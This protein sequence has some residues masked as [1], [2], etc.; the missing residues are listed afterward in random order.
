MERSVSEIFAQD[1]EAAFRGIET[2]ALKNLSQL[3]NFV[4]A[5]GGGTPCFHKNMRY[6][7]KNGPS[8]YLKADPAFLASR[9]E[10][11]KDRP[12]IQGLHGAELKEKLETI[13]AER[14]PFYEKAKFTMD[15]MNIGNEEIEEMVKKIGK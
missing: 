12:L 3:D 6:M 8:F 15:A 11:S 5:T 4:M 9:L 13:L 7:R 10:Q 1:G 14:S 2:M